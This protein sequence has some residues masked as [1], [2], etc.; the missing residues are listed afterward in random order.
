MPFAMASIQFFEYANAVEND[1]V[2]RTIS[3]KHYLVHVAS[4]FMG[5]SNKPIR[6]L[7]SAL[8]IMDEILE[9]GGLL[10]AW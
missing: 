3:E 6:E 8:D 5:T 2:T 1:V 7:G 9:S 4:Q 10:L